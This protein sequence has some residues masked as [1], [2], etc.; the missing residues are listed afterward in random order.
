LGSG[1]LIVIV[2]IIIGGVFFWNEVSAIINDATAFIKTT[3][4]DNEI[5]IPTPATGTR[6][7]DLLITVDIR[8]KSALS[9]STLIGTERILFTDGQEGK[10]I[11]WVW[12]N[13]HLFSLSILSA[14]QLDL[15]SES[16]F[17]PL[18][19]FIPA[20]DV[21]D[22]QIILSYVIVNENGLEKKL[23][24]YQEVSY[25]HPAFIADFD[26]Q[27]KLK[28]RDLKPGDYT[29]EIIP[30][31]AHFDNKKLG[32]SLKKTITFSD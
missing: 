3:A 28:Y 4:G 5:K 12:S 13:C 2:I 26:F 16:K 30:D 31:E 15:I 32:E 8:S 27:Q 9:G 23:S 11:T 24:F 6:V 14:T 29:L 21:F 7:C 18:E 22:Q 19:F 17:D 1:T 10:L 25:I 20:E